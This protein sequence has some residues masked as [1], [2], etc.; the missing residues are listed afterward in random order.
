MTYYYQHIV[1]I[2]K[3]IIKPAYHMLY[4]LYMIVLL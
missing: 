2:N 1:H 4:L 3:N